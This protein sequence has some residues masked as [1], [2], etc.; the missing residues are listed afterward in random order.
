MRVAM[1]QIESRPKPT[2]SNVLIDQNRV[3]VRNDGDE[4]GGSG[5]RLVRLSVS[6]ARIRNCDPF[7]HI[8]VALGLEKRQNE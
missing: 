8:A 3:P 7:V 1:R 2:K 5:G 4:A 6:P